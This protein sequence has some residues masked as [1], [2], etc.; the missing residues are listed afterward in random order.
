MQSAVI[1]GLSAVLYGEI[2]IDKG[3]VVQENFPD[4]QMVQLS[5]CPAIDVYLHESD[6]PLGGAGEPGVPPVAP[7]L[8]NAI[9]A[10]SGVRI[11]ELPVKK[12]SLAKT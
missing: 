8:T 6:A 3:A 4:Y 7:A 5:G 9:F 2:T 11:R 12:H 1:F 10:A